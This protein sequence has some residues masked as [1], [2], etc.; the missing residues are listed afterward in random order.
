M[1]RGDSVHFYKARGADYREA[2]ARS[3]AEKWFMSLAIAALRVEAK[4]TALEPHHV[5]QVRVPF[6]KPF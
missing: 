1:Q 4:A 5:V 6:A 3:A 2:K